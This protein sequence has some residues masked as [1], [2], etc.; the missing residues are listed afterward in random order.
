[1][2][3]AVNKRR[4]IYGLVDRQFLPGTFRVFDFANPDITIA[5]RHATTVPQQ[6]LFFLNHRLVADR[7]KAL[8]ARVDIA[9]A[10]SPE[11][12]VTRLYRSIYQRS[13]SAQETAAALRFIAAAEPEAAVQPPPPV[14]SAWQ[15]GWGEYDATAQR[16]KKFKALPHFNGKAW[17]GG[18]TFPDGK[19][20]WVQ[21]TAGGGHPG[22]DLKHACIRRWVA[23]RAG[24]VAIS[25]ELIHEPEAGDGIR[26]FIISSRQ[27]ELKTAT[28]HHSRIEMAAPN[29]EVQPGDTVDF[30]VDIAGEL[31][32]DQFLWAPKIAS[33]DAAPATAWDAEKEFAGPTPPALQP[34]PPWAQYA[35]VLLLANEFSFVD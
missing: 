2:L 20:G 4:T 16:V 18:E 8:A 15:Y 29:V 14:E 6:A 31:N 34:L 13:P 1:L 3:A 26:A 28:L 24:T 25:G 9:G 21:L 33:L 17:Q 35:Q 23:P 22:N 10:A 32:S 12:R 30:I 27:G 19:L 7:A 11:E 5:Q